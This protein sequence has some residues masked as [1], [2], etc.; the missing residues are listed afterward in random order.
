MSAA[1]DR[2]RDREGVDR[3]DAPAD[4]GL[5]SEE[6]EEEE[7]EAAAG[8][9]VLAIVTDRIGGRETID[10]LRPSADGSGLELRIVVPA[11]EAT[12]FRHTLGDVDEPREEAEQRLRTVLEELRRNG[13]EASGEV[14]DPDPIQA[15]EDALLKAPADEVVIFEN[16]GD[17]ARWFEDGLFERARECLDPPLRMVEVRHEP[18]GEDHVVDVET[19]GRGVENLDTGHE[20]GSAYVP[21]LSRGDF[22]GMVAGIVGTIVVA[23][24]AAAITGRSETAESGWEAAAILIAIGVALV[25]MAHV[26]GLTLMESVHYRGG[27]AKLFRTLS[28]VLT[29]TAALVNLLILL[30]A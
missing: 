25:N 7:E 2:D 23:V 1:E 18:S 19:A 16:A 21:N 26:V 29:P 9:R 24:L 10:Q 27:F 14:G 6:E 30:L 20:V 13:V 22:A 11:V 15:A 8:H 3:E 28:L 12:S 17:Q 5:V 4:E